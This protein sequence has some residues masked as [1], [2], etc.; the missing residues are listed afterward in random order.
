MEMLSISLIDIIT[1]RGRSGGGV[2]GRKKILNFSL[3]ERRI[4]IDM[5]DILNKVSV[6]RISII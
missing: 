5:F 2:G 4:G 6:S 3:T 1:A